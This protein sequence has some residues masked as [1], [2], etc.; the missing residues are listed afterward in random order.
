MAANE[1][2]ILR[3][4]TSFPARSSAP[5]SSK[6][7]KSPLSMDISACLLSMLVYTAGQGLAAGAART[8]QRCNRQLRHCTWKAAQPV[9]ALQ[10]Y[11][12]TCLPNL[13]ALR[14]CKIYERVLFSSL[15]EC[16]IEQCKPA[17]Y[18]LENILPESSWSKHQM[19]PWLI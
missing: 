17:L 1:C 6:C 2:C 8:F 11:G 13:L 18:N 14:A 4:Q 12:H 9:M 10:S 15:A 7:S 5:A 19:A 16:N 3:S